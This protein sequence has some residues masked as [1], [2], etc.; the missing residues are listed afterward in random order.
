[1]I[2]RKGVDRT[3]DDGSLAHPGGGQAAAEQFTEMPGHRT[4]EVDRIAAVVVLRHVPQ[5]KRLEAAT[6][7]VLDIGMVA[8]LFNKRREGC[9]VAARQ[10]FT[11]DL[12][13][14]GRIVDPEAADQFVRQV[15]RKQSLDEIGEQLPAEPG[16]AGLV[17]EDKTAGPDVRDNLPAVVK[18]AVGA[19][20]Q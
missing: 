5:Q 6:Q 17:A 15:L 8:V 9:Q 4:G 10:R 3:L 14:D 12:L 16:A 19:G 2:L 7:Q 1:M 18:A 11:V 20:A 13:H